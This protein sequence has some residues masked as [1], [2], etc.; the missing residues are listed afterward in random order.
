MGICLSCT[1]RKRSGTVKNLVSGA[2]SAEPDEDVRLCI[3]V[4]LTDVALDL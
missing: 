1:C 3:S 4:P 2:V